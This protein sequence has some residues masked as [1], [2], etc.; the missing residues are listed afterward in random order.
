MKSPSEQKIIQIELTNACPHSCSNCTRFCGRHSK[1]FFA[2]EGQFR[3][4]VDSMLGFHGMV[5]IMGG[6]PTIH[7]K[8]DSFVKYYADKIHTPPFKP[9][10][11]AVKDFAAYRNK[12]LSDVLLSKR[13]LWTSLGPGYRKH[14]ELIQDVFPYQC[15][16]DH[17]HEGRHQMLLGCRKDF[18][19]S[20]EEWIPLRDAC[21]IQNMW[22]ASITPKGAYFCEVAGALDILYNSPFGDVAWKVEKGWWERAPEEFGAQLQFCELCSAPLRVPHTVASHKMDYVSKWHS[23]RLKSMGIRKRKAACVF[24]IGAYRKEDYPEPG[25]TI[26]PYLPD[27]DNSVRISGTEESI[28]SYGWRLLEPGSSALT[29]AMKDEL[30][31]KVA[32]LILNPGCKYIVGDNAFLIHPTAKGYPDNYEGDKIVTLDYSGKDSEP[33]R[34]QKFL[35]AIWDDLESRPEP[36]VLYG[37]GRFLSTML[38][39]N[40]EPKNIKAIWDS[41]PK[42]KEIDGHPVKTIIDVLD[43]SDSIIFCASDAHEAK[44]K[45]SVRAWHDSHNSFASKKTE[46]RVLGVSDF[47]HLAGLDVYSYGMLPRDMEEPKAPKDGIYP[48]GVLGCVIVCAGY[49]DMLAWTLPLNKRHFDRMVVVTSYEDA[50]T[51]QLCNMLG[52]ISHP[53]GME[54]IHKNGAAFNKGAMINAG[55]E[56]GGMAAC[57]TIILTDADC[58]LPDDLRETLESRHYDKDVLYFAGRFNIPEDRREEWLATYTNDRSNKDDV[59]FLHSDPVGYFQMFRTESNCLTMPTIYSETFHNAGGSD[60]EFAHSRFKASHVCLEIPVLHIPHGPLA[61]NWAGRT[62]KT[63][64]GFTIVPTDA[65]HS[66]WTQIGYITG[67][68]YCELS[69]LPSTGTLAIIR[70]ETGER[71][72]MELSGASCSFVVSYSPFKIGLMKYQ[73][74]HCGVMTIEGSKRFY[75]HG[76]EIGWTDFDVLWIP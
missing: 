28:K 41:N 33:S 62:S 29:D 38:E 63:L 54:V 64:G 37:A 53:V 23:D 39:V 5:G 68:R 44:M 4:A 59:A 50:Q 7:P 51:R 60:F 42:C 74:M 25:L 1:P 46:C 75:W 76:K 67:S 18:G 49:S 36:V 32:E 3:K 55:I 13:G 30:K 6:E 69:P 31:K 61:G 24:P 56:W 12:H 40:P 35:K 45:A 19:I 15:I 8:F 11:Q 57:D 65:K 48:L 72:E 9:M 2:E 27:G 43:Y 58:I 34:Y 22:S 66:K 16:N 47:Y 52:V 21:W 14:F 10:R 17:S 20:D 26:E 73:V 71:C 70:T